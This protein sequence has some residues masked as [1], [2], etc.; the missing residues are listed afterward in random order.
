V[1]AGGKMKTA[2]YALYKGETF[3]D[4]GTAKEL[5]DKFHVSTNFIQWLAYPTAL[6]RYN[7]SNG[8]RMIAVKLGEKD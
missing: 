8:N 1:H 5:A 4:I 2:E 3:L 7:E 6:K